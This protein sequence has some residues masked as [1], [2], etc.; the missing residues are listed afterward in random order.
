MTLNRTALLARGWPVKIF[1]RVLRLVALGLWLSPAAFGQSSGAA[2]KILVGSDS[3]WSLDR[4][5]RDGSQ[6][7]FRRY[8]D[9]AL[10]SVKGS[11]VTSVDAVTSDSERSGTQVALSEPQRNGFQMRVSEEVLVVGKSSGLQPGDVLYLGP[12][13]SPNVGRTVAVI[14]PLTPATKY[15]PRPGEG[16]PG[17]AL[18]NPN[19]DYRPEWDSKL[20]PGY[21][22]PFSNSSSDYAEGRTLPYPP[23]NGVQR[24]HGYP[25]MVI[26]DGAEPPRVL[27]RPGGW[28]P[29]VNNTSIEPRGVTASSSVIPHV[30][31]IHD[32]PRMG[33]DPNLPPPGQTPTPP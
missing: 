25:P 24:G 8:P 32:V 31:D 6:L 28:E 2:F 10:V 26:D 16:L 18:F 12:T 14:R 17:K 23:G 13:A 15:I 29:P 20:V 3:I 21:S 5:R 4:P 9:G 30:P 11:A 7:V 1:S 19:R 27:S 22:M 33:Y